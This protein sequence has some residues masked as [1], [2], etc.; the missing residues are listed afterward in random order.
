M[1]NKSKTVSKTF[2]HR[3]SLHLFNPVPWNNFS[4]SKL[5]IIKLQNA[6]EK[7]EAE[8]VIHLFI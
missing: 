8:Q 2:T 1:L 5:P 6:P 4:L 7:K 3:D